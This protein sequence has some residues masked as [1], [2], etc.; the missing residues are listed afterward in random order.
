MEMNKNMI[1]LSNVSKSYAIDDNHTEL[2]LE[3]INLNVSKSNITAIYGPSGCGKTTLLNIISGLDRNFD[4]E[5]EFGNESLTSLNEEELTTFRKN[6]IGFVFQNFN[7]IPH[8]SVIDNV[9][10]AMYLGDKRKQE[11]QSRAESV[12]EKVGLLDMKDKNIT[13]LSGGQ[14]QRVAIARALINNPNVIIAD[15]PTGSLDSESQKNI[16]NILTNLK[17][18]GKTIIIVTHNEEVSAI[19]NTIINMKDGKI[20]SVHQNENVGTKELSSSLSLSKNRLRLKLTTYLAYKN[21]SQRKWRNILIS[22]ATSIGL[23]GILISFGLGNGI[24]K[25]IESEVDNG[26]LPSQ[27]QISIDNSKSVSGILNKDDEDDLINIVGK[28]NVK[29]LES[30]FSVQITNISIE[31]LGDIDLENTL[32]A[33]SQ[34]ISLYKDTEISVSANDKSE[35]L[36]GEPYKD[37]NEVG[38]TIP[39]SLLTDFINENKPNLNLSEFMNKSITI[40]VSEKQI[41]GTITGSYTTKIIRIVDDEVSESN[42]FMS[43]K[44]LE[45]VIEANGMS[46]NVPYIILELKDPSKTKSTVQKIKETNKYIALSQ[47]EILTL[48]INFIKIIQGLLIVLSFQAIIVSIVMI[49]VI[50]Y[51]NIIERSKEIGVMRTIGYSNKNIKSIF[52]MESLL[53]TST[54][55][56]IS[57]IISYL[58]GSIINLIISSK[59]SQIDQIFYLDIR[60]ILFTTILSM[61]IGYFAAYI[62]SLK[63]S[64]LDIVESLRYE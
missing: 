44:E 25:M 48:I 52:T 42:S 1:K 37:I 64:K 36:Y 63:I 34:I 55:L 61:L 2:V 35:I 14:K 22:I 53:I 17:N 40:N 21:F 26:G 56:I 30:P 62:P 50:V 11:I 60:S 15:E 9:K 59:F 39:K 18:E 47:Q 3:N 31:D 27:I 54:A 24:I 58:I 33:Y 45:D 51:I 16:L 19:A 12:L 8:L 20:V 57:V 38:I 29:Y 10:L 28:N 13:K 46:K 4:G 41:D 49:S 32:P 23:I 6:N 5:I 43:Y 7:L